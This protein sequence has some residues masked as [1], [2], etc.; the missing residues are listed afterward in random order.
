MRW[1]G[2]LVDRSG[3]IGDYSDHD[4][5]MTMDL[6]VSMGGGRDIENCCF[7]GDGRGKLRSSIGE[8]LFSASVLHVWQSRFKQRRGGNRNGSA[9]RPV[10]AD[11]SADLHTAHSSCPRRFC[12]FLS[13]P[14][15]GAA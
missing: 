5:A 7:R 2:V 14:R 15:F 11:F 9:L 1:R 12:L 3:G 6:S 13:F 4:S 10:T 8:E